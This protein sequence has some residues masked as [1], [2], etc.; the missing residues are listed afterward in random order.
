MPNWMSLATSIVAIGMLISPIWFVTPVAAQEEIPEDCDDATTYSQDD[1]I[2]GTLHPSDSDVFKLNI[3]KSDRI[4]VTIVHDYEF[5]GV[6]WNHFLFDDQMAINTQ[7]GTDY[8]TTE[9]SEHS[10]SGP[11]D[12][13][14]GSITVKGDTDRWV[15]YLEGEVSGTPCIRFQEGYED[16]TDVS[17]D[18]TIYL[19][20]SAPTPTPT[21][22]PTPTPTPTPSPTPTSTPS[23]TSTTTPFPTAGDESASI[24]TSKSGSDSGDD[25]QDSDGD[26]MVDS[27]DYAPHDPEVQEKSDLQETSGG[28]GAGFGV[29]VAVVALLIITLVSLRGR[30]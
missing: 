30:D 7:Y 13:A 28:S 5:P 26:G 11:Y 29:G 25:L 21:L 16:E 19:G 20:S 27:E 23:L 3:D 22:T 15:F 8:V 9:S 18:Y 14:H 6:D 24:T 12:A 1:V 10:R 17:F 4:K 2:E